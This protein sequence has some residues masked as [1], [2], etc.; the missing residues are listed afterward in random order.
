MN[1]SVIT[2]PVS[3]AKLFFQT[4]YELLLLNLTNCFDSK[5]PIRHCLTETHSNLNANNNLTNFLKS[6][7]N[8]QEEILASDPHCLDKNNLSLFGRMFNNDNLNSREIYNHI[9]INDND[10]ENK[11]QFWKLIQDLL[12]TSLVLNIYKSPIFN[13]LSTLDLLSSEQITNAFSQIQ[14][15]YLDSKQSEELTNAFSQIQVTDFDKLFTNFKNLISILNGQDLIDLN[16]TLPSNIT[17]EM[18]NNTSCFT[19]L[20]SIFI[21]QQAKKTQ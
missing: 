18:I 14:V 6:V 2:S 9:L 8:C 4:N 16:N 20:A 12:K 7:E 5:H 13:I 17:V 15:T 21:S 1:Y 3:D 10:N 19:E 11:Q